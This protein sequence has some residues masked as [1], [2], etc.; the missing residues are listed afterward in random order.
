[1]MNNGTSRRDFFKKAGLAAGVGAAGAVVL[2]KEYVKPVVK[3]LEPTSAYAQTPAISAILVS[4]VSPH[5]I[6]GTPAF[7][8]R[9]TLVG[10]P[11]PLVGI[12]IVVTNRFQTLM[13]S[14]NKIT[15]ALLGAGAPSPGTN[16]QSHTLWSVATSGADGRVDLLYD[17]STSPATLNGVSMDNPTGGSGTDTYP[18]TGLATLATLGGTGASGFLTIEVA[19]EVTTIGSIT[20]PETFLGSFALNM[21]TS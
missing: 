21:V 17:A 20:Y 16:K 10:S 5:N 7:T 3:L 11:D 13:D 8:F 9:F 12:R 1:M 15:L 19:S 14:A 2:K 6:A 18:G 4:P